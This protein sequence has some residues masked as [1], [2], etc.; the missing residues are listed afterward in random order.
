MIDKRRTGEVLP[1][2]R[3]DCSC[4]FHFSGRYLGQVS[5][6]F[7]QLTHEPFSLQSLSLTTLPPSSL[8]NVTF[9]VQG[10]RTSLASIGALYEA[11]DPPVPVA[12]VTELPEGFSKQT[13][14]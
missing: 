4:L 5:T 10:E 2:R 7:M 1:A 3:T 12:H 8:R 6:A 13:F 9:R 14:I 11:R